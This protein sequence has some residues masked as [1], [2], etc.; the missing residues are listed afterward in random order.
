MPVNE[1]KFSLTPGLPTY[2]EARAFLKTIQGV[3]HSIFNRM[4]DRI[5]EQVGT[6]QENI[7]WT[8]PEEWIPLRLDGDEQDLA[9]KIWRE[10]KGL[11][12]PRHIRGCWYLASKHNLIVVDSFENIEITIGGK[13]F[14]T[15]SSSENIIEIDV[16]EGLLNIL[17]VVSEHSPGKRSDILP[18]F[19]EFCNTY[20]NYRSESVYKSALYDRMVNLLER[21]LINKHGSVFYEVSEKGI[22]YLR[23]VSH[24][25]PGRAVITRQTELNKSAQSITQETRKRLIEFL[26]KM[27]PYKF[28]H[29]VGLL[30]QEMGYADIEVTSPSNDKGVDVVA[31]IELGISSIREVVQVKR[32]S[33]SINRTV[34]DMLRGSLHRFNAFRGTII[35]TGSFSAGAKSAALEMGAAPITLIDGKKLLDLLIEYGI[36]VS[37]KAV[38]FYEFDDSKL[39]EFDELNV[40]QEELENRSL[41]DS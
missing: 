5:W 8:S 28:E 18:S 15:D 12:N 39:I 2:S 21:G 24:L 13:S 36:G 25:I 41:P 27:D 38:E 17:Q 37:K 29:L 30:L 3:S 14:Q 4:R 31:N 16:K 6:P 20:T 23:K 10:T 32:H 33:G 35:S 1:S 26:S 9:L 34:L 40:P 11:V 19:V 7:N 22:Q